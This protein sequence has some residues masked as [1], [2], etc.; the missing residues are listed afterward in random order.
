MND[1]SRPGVQSRPL[2]G[3]Q[4]IAITGNLPM[5]NVTSGPYCMYC[6]C[7]LLDIEYLT[8]SI[9]YD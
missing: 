8:N 1:P 5:F 7:Y 6:N 2:G 3:S 9:S 4:H